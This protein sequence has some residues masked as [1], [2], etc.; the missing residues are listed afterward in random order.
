VEVVERI[1]HEATEE[2]VLKFIDEKY[3]HIDSIEA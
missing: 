2:L 3:T 1:G